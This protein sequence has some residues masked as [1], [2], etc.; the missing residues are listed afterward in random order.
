MYRG[1]GASRLAMQSIELKRTKVDLDLDPS[2]TKLACNACHMFISYPFCCRV[3][4]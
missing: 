2:L 4:D 1:V 3:S